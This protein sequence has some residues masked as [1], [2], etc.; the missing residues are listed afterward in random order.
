MIQR[1]TTGL[2]TENKELKLRLQAMEQ[3]AQ[4]RDALNEKLKEEV[5]RLR[6]Q[7]GQVSAMNGNPFNR[8]L[9]PQYLTH[10]PAPHHF[11]VLQT[12]QQQQQQQQQQQLHMPHSSTNNPTLNGQPQ[13]CFMDFNQRA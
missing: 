3:Q 11:G 13:P 4:L 10:Q 1:D 2:T 9:S 8:G 6:I 7:A 5:Q 12:P